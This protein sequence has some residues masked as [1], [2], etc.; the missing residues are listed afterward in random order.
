MSDAR[1][2]KR[3]GI[4]DGRVIAEQI[5]NEVAGEVQRLRDEHSVKPC[6]AAVLAGDDDASAVYV[7]NKM[8]ACAE[9]GIESAQHAL[10]AETTTASLLALISELNQRDDV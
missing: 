2:A 1:Q 4:L 10:P 3:A 5:K 8:R 9:V 6:L 7:R